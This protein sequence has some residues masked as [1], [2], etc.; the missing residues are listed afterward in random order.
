M[1][2]AVES[3]TIDAKGVP[4]EIL[5]TVINLKQRN[6][7]NLSSNSRDKALLCPVMKFLPVHANR[8]SFEIS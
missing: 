2:S 7:L 4:A 3:I 1:G 8:E 6:E 5:T